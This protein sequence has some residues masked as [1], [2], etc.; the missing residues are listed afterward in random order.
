MDFRRREL[1]LG[2][3]SFVLLFRRRRGLFSSVLFHDR[4]Y[5]ARAQGSLGSFKMIR[6]RPCATPEDAF[7]RR[8]GLLAVLLNHGP[9]ARNILKRWPPP[10]LSHCPSP[11]ESGV[12]SGNLKREASG[13]RSS[14]PPAAYGRR[15]S[16]YIVSKYIVSLRRKRRPRSGRP[17]QAAAA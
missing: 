16:K 17:P 13:V 3:F 11:S 6:T 15:Q 9:W 4:E 14:G 7:R 5:D 1:L 2:L 12:S 8:Q 10:I